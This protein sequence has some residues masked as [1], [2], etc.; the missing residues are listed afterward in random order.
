MARQRRGP[1]ASAARRSGRSGLAGCRKSATRNGHDPTRAGVWRRGSAARVGPSGWVAVQPCRPRCAGAGG[2]P[3][4]GDPGAGERGTGAAVAGVR[5]APARG[6]RD[7]IAPE[8]PLR[9]QPHADR[10]DPR[11]GP[12]ARR[13]APN[14]PA[15]A[16]TGRPERHAPSGRLQ[17]HP[18]GKL[19]PRAGAIVRR[20]LDPVRRLEHRARALGVAG[21][22]AQRL[23]VP[24]AAAGA[25]E[26]A[27]LVV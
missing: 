11:P 6:G 2:S 16:R 20:L 10:G 4:A 18:H 23:R 5:P 13:H 7:L 25:E 12:G 8:K 15:R 19:S 1:E 9:A 17:P 14:P 21:L 24:L 26:V 3:A 27:A 22:L